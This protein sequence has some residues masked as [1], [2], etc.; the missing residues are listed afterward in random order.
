MPPQVAPKQMQLHFDDQIVVCGPDLQMSRHRGEGYF[1]CD[2]RLASGYR[3]HFGGVAPVLLDSCVVNARAARFEFTNPTLDEPHGP[4]QAGTL[5]LRVDRTLGHGVHDDYD[6]VNYGD[7]RVELVVELSI[8]CDFADLFDVRPNR[9][10]RRGAMQTSWDEAVPKVMTR[11]R[12]ERFTRALDLVIDRHD[13][14]PE[15]ANGGISFRICLAPGESWHTCVLWIPEIDGRRP[16]HPVRKCHDL[17]GGDSATDRA[18]RKWVESS[19]SFSTAN[20][21]VER[22]INQAVEDLASLRL[23][24][25]D[26]RARGTDLSEAVA[27]RN[28]IDPNAWV[29]AAGVPW[30]VTL[31]G[32]DSLIVSLQTFALS[33]R[34]AGGALTALGSLQADDYDSH[35][36]MEPGKIIHEVRHGELAQL[37]LIPHTPY[38]GT[39]DATPLFVWT[40]ASMWQWDGQREHLDRIRPNVERALAWIDKDGDRDGDGLQEYETRAKSGGYFNQGWKDSGDAIVHADGSLP[41]TPIALCELQGYVVTAKRAWADVLDDVYR[42]Q[43]AARRL[44]DEADRLAEQIDAQFW[45]EDEGT[46]YLGLD[47]DKQP[48]R[49]VASNAGHLLW[50]RAVPDER[51]ARVAHRLLAPDM[52]SGWG[53]R[54]LSADHCAY[55][56]MSYQ[57]GSVWPHDNACISA[58]MRA[59]DLHDEAD[60]ITRALFEATDQLVGCRLPE[61]FSGFPRDEGGFPV[62]YVDANVPQAWAAGAVVHLATTLLGFDPHAAAGS[63]TISPALPTWLPSIGV[64]NLHVGSARVDFTVSRN[65]DDYDLAVERIDGTLDVTLAE[66]S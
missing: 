11:Y 29:P 50:A 64:R 12:N 24:T 57:R 60:Q 6:V 43:T 1:V 65:D 39:H 5:H 28:D 7:D 14:V 19:A 20:P 42:E 33:S 22:A 21:L 48:I 49:S 27:L 55:N 66:R 59:Y 2:T 23:H 3:I 36:D 30:Y 52:W 41:S 40:A 26:E 8:E 44:R 45:W 35:R 38:Y 25:Y 9:L 53:V 61:L 37:G 10:V 62:R 47:A 46:Y 18:H 54:T 56:P 34:F 4:V 58:G 15:F 16:E 63:L 32:R 13:S 17:L 31:F 51:A